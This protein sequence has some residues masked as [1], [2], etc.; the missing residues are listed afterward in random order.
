MAKIKGHFG[1]G[2]MPTQPREVTG[3]APDKY[4]LFADGGVKCPRDRMWNLGG[5]GVW[6]PVYD[7]NML[8][9]D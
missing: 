2:I 5:F 4:N 8:K 7:V 9:E 1:Q 3:T 6:C